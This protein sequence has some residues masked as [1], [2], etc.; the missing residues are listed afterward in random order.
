MLV[1]L[2]ALRWMACV[3]Q[4]RSWHY[5]SHCNKK[6][7]TFWSVLFVCSFSGGDRSHNGRVH[8]HSARVH[9]HS[10]SAHDRSHNGRRHSHRCLPDHAEGHR[11][12][13]DR[14][15][16]C[17]FLHADVPPYHRSR[18]RRPVPSAEPAVHRCMGCPDVLPGLTG[19]VCR[20]LLPYLPAADDVPLQGRISSG[21]H[22]TETGDTCF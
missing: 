17:S 21:K 19:S 4:N 13:G 14:C 20:G 1:E 18:I 3:L 2:S 12:C 7:R 11:R 8:S 9:G 6:G 10:R 22:R 5:I 15:L 16:G